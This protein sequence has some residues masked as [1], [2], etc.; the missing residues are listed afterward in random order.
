MRMG[1]PHDPI[2]SLRDNL[3]RSVVGWGA[4]WVLVMAVVMALAAQNEVEDLADASLQES[5]E[6]LYEVFLYAPQALHTPSREQ[7]LPNHHEKLIWQWVDQAGQVQGRSHAAPVLPLRAVEEVGISNSDARWRVFGLVLP[8]SQGVVLVADRLA[9]RWT[10]RIQAA[11]VAVGVTMVMGIGFVVWLR[12]RMAHELG[13]LY[14]F[15]RQVVAYDPLNNRDAMQ[16]PVW[17]ELLP[18]RDAVLALGKRLLA[19]VDRERAF[20]AHAAHAL[21]T[22]L[23][24]IDAQL[25]VALRECPPHLQPRLKRTREAAGRLGQVVASLLSLFRRSDHM[26]WSSLDLAEILGRTGVPGVSIETLGQTLVDGDAEWLSVAFIN[27]LDN[28]VR[29]GGTA[30]VV[31]VHLDT[32]FQLIAL[33][34]NGPGI[35]T[36]RMHALNQ[37]LASQNYE[38][39]M[40]LGLMLADWVARAHGGTIRLHPCAQPGV[41]GTRVEMLLRR[42]KQTYPSSMH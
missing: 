18:I 9:E 3:L 2:P 19:R 38:G 33:E 30:V 31:R 40:G 32:Q 11:L 4:V 39:H 42:V 21:R 10:T 15:S 24:G 23:A 28:V 5:A 22:P 12:R 27:L 26:E 14:Q 17:V 16:H 7:P 37:A 36:D 35:P 34:D 20:S 8:D 6:W 29:H 13:G 25:A 41:A 1:S